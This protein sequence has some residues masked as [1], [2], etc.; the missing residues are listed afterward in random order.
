ELANLLVKKY[1]IPFRISHK[2]VG[3][4]IKTLLDKKIM[5]SDLTPGILNN[6]AKDF[7]GN[8]LDVKL[9]DIKESIDP[10]KVVNNHNIMGGPAP[11][12]V[13]RMI[14]FHI[15]LIKK[16]KSTV[17]GYKTDLEKANILLQSQIE[18]YQIIQ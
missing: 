13:K 4:V 11:D 9:I 16:S 17:K 2:I 12:E 10:Q 15:K 18:K 7:T 8:S 6:I 3:A 5:L 14:K 1:G